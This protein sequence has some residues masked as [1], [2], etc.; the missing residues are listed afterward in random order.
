MMALDADKVRFIAEN[1]P[2]KAQTDHRHYAYNYELIIEEMDDARLWG[3]LPVN[4]KLSSEWG[5]FYA[6]IDRHTYVLSEDQDGGKYV[7]LHTD[8]ESKRY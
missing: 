3:E 6:I 1:I 5:K 7:R 4:D 8:E 2:V